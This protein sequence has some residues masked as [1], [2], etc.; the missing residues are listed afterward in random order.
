MTVFKYALLRFFRKPAN[1]LLVL[2]VPVLI[3]LISNAIEDGE[4][5]VF[6][7]FGLTQLFV[8]A[9]LA[10][11]ISED[12]GKKAVV[13]IGVAPISHFNYLTSNVLAYTLVLIVQ[14]F[15]TF[16]GVRL[17]FDIS[18]PDIMQ[19]VFLYSVF[20]LT[21][22]SLSM[23]WYNLYRNRSVSQL[24]LLTFSAIMG[25]LG[26]LFIPVEFFPNWMESLSRIFPTYWLNEG[27]QFI[28]ANELGLD[29][30]LTLVI[31]GLYSLVFL[32]IGSRRSFH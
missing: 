19:Y 28:L 6:Q 27:V 10:D 2:I 22:I 3:L 32:I 11:V 24:L 13:R 5:L 31:L 21:S 9:R 16:A 15:L 17:L 20:A 14:V 26:G 7:L 18:T 25:T 4:I 1:I 23:A 8:A 12:R 30:F 29:F